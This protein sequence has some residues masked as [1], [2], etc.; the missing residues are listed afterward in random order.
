M[1]RARTVFLPPPLGGLNTRDPKDIVPPSDAIVLRNLYPERNCLSLREFEFE[2]VDTGSLGAIKTLTSFVDDAGNEVLIAASNG[3]IIDCT[4]GVGGYTTLAAATTF[5]NDYWQT[6]LFGNHLILVNGEDQPQK[7]YDN[8]GTITLA[9]ATY[10]GI[11][12]DADLIQVTAYR[13]RL[14][15]AATSGQIWYGGMDAV[16]GA[17]TA[18]D[19]RSLMKRGGLPSVVATWTYD[20]SGGL[21]DRL[22]I[23]GS[24]GDLLVY[25]GANP[26][27]S[28]WKIIAHF[29]VPRPVGK[30]CVVKH[31][32]D[33]FI[34]TEGGVFSLAKLMQTAQAGGAVSYLT[35]K[36]SPTIRDYIY[37]YSENL[38]AGDFPC[39]IAID[40]SKN[41]LFVVIANPSGIGSNFGSALMLV[42]NLD[43]GAWCEYDG[44]A[45]ST[46]CYFKNEIYFAKTSENG[47]VFALKDVSRETTIPIAPTGIDPWMVQGMS[48]LETQD[49]AVPV[50]RRI[51]AIKPLLEI[52]V[53]Y[54]DEYLPF[55]FH[56]IPPPL[57][58][59]A[60]GGKKYIPA[61]NATFSYTTTSSYFQSMYSLQKTI[62]ISAE[63]IRFALE[64]YNEADFTD[65]P[66]WEVGAFYNWGNPVKYM[67]SMI[68]FT[69]GGLE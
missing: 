37:N 51:S 53:A 63:G 66:D 12:D 29:I 57:N 46:L 36:V 40:Q 5:D 68:T 6:I 41:K 26:A 33:L 1:S 44:M 16:V 25:E 24:E 9:A 13:N 8:A 55:T 4:N 19:I 67:G 52:Y 30:R 10:T 2:I 69:A 15:F 14:Y 48:G 35:D 65:D 64:F 27:A 23:L 50:I 59:S 22:V 56:L 28:D 61:A 32:A 7:I 11:T 49:I 31:G 43:T 42:M 18:F 47:V 34:L 45:S 54:Q 20:D 60:L 62:P 17:L 38:E 21:D 3:G 39:E 58:D